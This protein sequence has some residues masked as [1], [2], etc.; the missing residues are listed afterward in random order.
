ML[1]MFLYVYIYDICIY[2]Y[3]YTYIYTYIYIEGQRERERERERGRE[4]GREA[5]RER[6]LTQGAL[7]GGGGGGSLRPLLA[8]CKKSESHR[9]RDR[10]RERSPVAGPLA[11]NVFCKSLISQQ[12]ARSTRRFA[13]PVTPLSC[14]LDLSP[15]SS[16]L[17][18]RLVC[19]YIQTIC[20]GL[21]KWW[22]VI[23]GAPCP[24]VV[25]YCNYQ[26]YWGG[27][28]IMIIV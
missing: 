23:P 13:Q 18:N 28:L 21:C 7:A 5:G 9:A 15:Q 8:V 24:A 17:R 27:V 14:P 26:Y 6:D 19:N 20:W 22:G 25:E 12:A 2:I 1:Y 10:E 11:H 16:R 4:G 3:I